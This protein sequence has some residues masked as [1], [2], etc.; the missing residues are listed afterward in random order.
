M[1]AEV[2]W[3]AEAAA[4]ATGGAN[5]AAWAA[6]GVSIDTRTLR[7]GDLFVALAGP[8]FDG[9]DFI[10][11][12][13]KKGAAAAIAHRPTGDTSAGPLLVVADTLAALWRLGAAARA[14]GRARVIGVTGSVGKTSTKEALA[15][16]LSAAAP[17]AASAGSL[18]NH[19]GVPLSL[20]RLPRAAAYGVFELG[21]NHPGEIRDLARLL[22]PEVAL[23]TNVEA[24]HIGY[25]RSIEEI[26]EAKAEIFEGMG[27]DGTAVLNRDNRHFER[28]AAAARTAGL[29]RV[30]GFGRG[31]EAEVRLIDCTL[32]ATRSRVSAEVFGRPVTYLL[33]VPGTHWVAN[34]LAVLATVSA[35]GADVTAAAAAM[36]RLVPVKGRGRRH[37]VR[38]PDGAF[39]LIDD[40]YNANPTSMQAAFEVLGRTETG[41]G[42]RR[43]AALGDML[44]LGPDSA[45]MHRGLAGPLRAAG[46]DVV[47]TCG[48]DMAALNASLPQAMRGGHAADARALVPLVTAVVA[49]GDAVL[50]KGSA[51]SRMGLIAEALKGMS[52][53]LPRAANG[54]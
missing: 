37:A 14:R 26:A 17:T 36:G 15:A 54:G 30:V 51:G 35:A 33:S 29:R 31:A 34:S 23:I 2:L 48:R 38:L 6:T 45:A 49:A 3:T 27:P 22:R 4:E 16:C 42:G 39:V 7:S 40:S 28:L 8:N 44:E 41:P 47:F 52:Q 13:F 53:A 18:N 12:A 1:S 50:V 19:W 10:A 11:E 21:M 20:A 25:F 5:T 24:A 32:E 9:H 46:I 43:I